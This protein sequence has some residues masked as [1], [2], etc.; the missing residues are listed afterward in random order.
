MNIEEL[1]NEFADS[2]RKKS[3]LVSSR[4][5]KKLISRLQESDL[6]KISLTILQVFEFDLS[7]DFS[8]ENEED[9][10]ILQAF[11]D[12]VQEICVKKIL[13]DDEM[14]AR[15]EAQVLLAY[16]ESE[17]LD[18]KCQALMGLFMRRY[19]KRYGRSYAYR[20][21]R[22]FYTSRDMTNM[23]QIEKTLGAK[24]SDYINW[25]FDVKEPGFPT[26][27][28]DTNILASS[29]MM[30]E[31]QHSVDLV[32]K[33]VPVAKKLIELDSDF[34]QFIANL[35]ENQKGRYNYIRSVKDLDW[36][37]AIEQTSDVFE[38]PAIIKILKEARNRKLIPKLESL[39]EMWTEERKREFNAY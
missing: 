31:F 25:C 27:F 34:L 4:I 13:S 21:V 23:S 14:R 8:R 3:S 11:R 22:S 20:A 28:Y 35:S 29:S 2:V 19:R 9:S 30:N 24:G 10:F 15:N 6:R 12:F 18:R 36:L 26:G 1:R 39:P 37:L 33:D 5:L 16:D 7:R 17:P 32:R 38:E